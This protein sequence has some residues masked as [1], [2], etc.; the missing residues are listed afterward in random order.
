M[1]KV[2]EHIG[3]LDRMVDPISLYLVE[4]HGVEAGHFSPNLLSPD[5]QKR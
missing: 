4:V 2:E 3:L 5:S 1:E